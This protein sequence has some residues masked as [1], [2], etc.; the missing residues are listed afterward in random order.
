[1]TTRPVTGTYADPAGTPLTGRV[2]FQLVTLASDGEKVY[3]TNAVAALLD[4]NGHIAV[5]LVTTDTLDVNGICY[6][7]TEHLNG[8]PITRYY[9]ELPAA[10]D[11]LD[12][13]DADR[14]TETP[15]LYYPGGPR[16]IQGEQGEQG[17]QGLPGAPG[18]VPQK[19]ANGYW[20][21][22]T[23]TGTTTPISRPVGTLSLN[24]LFYLPEAKTLA[25]VAVEVQT[26]A[27]NSSVRLGVYS[28]EDPAAPTLVSD[29]GTVSGTTTGIKT[30]TPGIVL[31]PGVYSIGTAYQG[32]NA[33]T[34]QGNQCCLIAPVLL[35]DRA[36]A[37]SQ[38]S[39]LIFHATGVTGS[40]P[41]NPTYS[42]PSSWNA[43]ASYR[44]KF[45]APA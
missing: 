30:L 14:G 35:P 29:L 11:A 21:R 43:C 26:L 19:Y 1:M 32:S 27:S 39:T 10:P 33:C 28:W 16:G 20:Y 17:E 31:Q 22:P 44:V 5:E 2:V 13:A 23:M 9:I 18:F 34:L 8:Q 42:N 38:P 24:A 37:L 4:Q 15:R 41:S 45:A 36:P 7:V 3:G 12:L 40:L 25:E 6:R